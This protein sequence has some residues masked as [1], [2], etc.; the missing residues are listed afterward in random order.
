MLDVESV[1]ARAELMCGLSWYTS[2]TTM[3]PT[4]IGV[5]GLGWLYEAML[6]MSVCCDI[7]VLQYYTFN[8]VTPKDRHAHVR[9]KAAANRDSVSTKRLAGHRR[10]SLRST[11][12]MEMQTRSMRYI[13][14][15]VGDKFTLYYHTNGTLEAV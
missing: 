12:S 9:L 5:L 1:P 14:H 13:M 6:L 4:I 2:L 3:T 10:R 15:T 7:A 11:L 8:P